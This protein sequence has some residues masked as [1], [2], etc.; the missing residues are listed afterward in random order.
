MKTGI[1]RMAVATAIMLSGG[2]AFAQ[3]SITMPNN[4]AG[5]VL[6]TPPL[7]APPSMATTKPS[8]PSRTDSSL[9]AFDALDSKHQGYVT[10]GDISELPGNY[11]FD[12]ADRNHDGRLDSDEFQRFWQDYNSPGGQ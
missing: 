3:S 7:I 4:S 12:T 1:R 11:N 5:T 9:S 8:T 2:M 10:R 6:D